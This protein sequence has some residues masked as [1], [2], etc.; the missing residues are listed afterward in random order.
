MEP[1]ISNGIETNCEQKSMQ[2]SCEEIILYLHYL[3]K[4]IVQILAFYITA[5]AFSPCSDAN[6]LGCSNDLSTNSIELQDINHDNHSHDQEDDDCTPFCTCICCG[7]IID[8][9]ASNSIFLNNNDLA[10]TFQFNY[11]FNYSLD[12]LNTVWHPP[13]YS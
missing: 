10:S 13:T 6:L 11:F 5:L 1:I 3:M 7:T 4:Y 8:M 2:Q 9:P 12:Y